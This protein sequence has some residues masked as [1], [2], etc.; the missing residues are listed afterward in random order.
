MNEARVRA[1]TR[2]AHALGSSR[3]RRKGKAICRMTN[4]RRATWVASA[5]AGNGEQRAVS[6][7]AFSR[8]LVP[9][10]LC[11]VP[12]VS[13]PRAKRARLTNDTC[14]VYRRVDFLPIRVAC[15]R[16]TVVD[17]L[18][19]RAWTAANLRS[20]L[21]RRRLLD[22]DS[23]IVTQRE[24]DYRADTFWWSAQHARTRA[25]THTHMRKVMRAY[26]CGREAHNV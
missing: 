9:R 15:G 13:D 17:G 19:P 12:R 7:R 25:H 21:R 14:T 18:P 1:R 4:E 26:T 8:L 23:S 5:V 6:P 3:A 20:F 2:V 10:A 24:P 11:L 16:R 22:R